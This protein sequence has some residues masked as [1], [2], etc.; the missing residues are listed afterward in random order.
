MKNANEILK[1]LKDLDD[2]LAEKEKALD[3]PETEETDVSAELED[4][5][6]MS[7]SL[8]ELIRKLKNECN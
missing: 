7:N 2:V 5:K 3:N 1:K 4:L 8:L 6:E